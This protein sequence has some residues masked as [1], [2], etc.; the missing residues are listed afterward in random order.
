ME[1]YMS[2]LL[3]RIK[4]SVTYVSGNSKYVKINYEK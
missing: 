1:N 4:E 3:D 2:D